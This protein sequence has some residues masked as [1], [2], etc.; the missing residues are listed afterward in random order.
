MSHNDQNVMR[1]FAPPSVDPAAIALD[2]FHPLVNGKQPL[3]LSSNLQ[4]YIKAAQE[5]IAEVE[6]SGELPPME[7]SDVGIVA[8][9][10]GGSLPTK[11]RN[12]TH[13]FFSTPT[14]SKANILLISAVDTRKDPRM[15]KHFTRRRRR[16]LGST[17]ADVWLARRRVQCLAS[18]AR[19]QVYLHQPRPCRPS[20][21]AGAYTREAKSGKLFTCQRHHYTY[22]KEL[23]PIILARPPSD[24]TVVCRLYQKRTPLSPRAPR[25]ARYWHR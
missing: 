3:E 14:H 23:I 20:Y 24:G 5:N 17:R 15:R 7:G 19:Y 11:Y 2:K 18:I 25:C 9:G 4:R 1:P 8:L 12:G 13:A 21:W 6:A 16:Y 10:T 22:L